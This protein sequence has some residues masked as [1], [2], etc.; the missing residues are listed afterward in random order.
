[1]KTI[2]A[3]LVIALA[4]LGAA[5]G[6]I[7][8]GVPQSGDIAKRGFTKADF[9]RWKELAPNVYAYEGLEFP[10]TAEIVV[11]TV[12]LIVITPDGVVVVDGQG[13]LR[14][15]QEMIDTIKAW[16]P[17][18]IR[19]V[20]VASD[21][22]DHVGGNAAFKAAYPDVVFMSSPVSQRNLAKNANPPTETVADKRVITLG[23]TEI[24]VL[25]IGRGHTGGDLV[26]YL[27]ES[28]V[29]F[30][31]ELYMRHIFPALRSGYPSEWLATIKRAQ[32]MDVSWYV[33]GHGF[34]DDMASMK[35]D[36]EGYRVA[37]EYVIAEGKRLHALGLPCPNTGKPPSCEALKHAKWG[38]YI[39]WAWDE[40]QAR[41]AIAKVYQ[42][43]EG[44]LPQ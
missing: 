10:D 24:Q 12:S 20:V 29:L 37:L 19:Y 40:N 17:Q 36:L 21:H 9:P 18:P 28:K 41:L 33:P 1:M 15:T 8:A 11:T 6:A 43:I 39:D 26:A 25:S 44:R 42:E 35:A 3:L 23:G 22:I 13:D 27:P 14:Q 38:P 4:S 31:G 32:A 7:A 2:A 5:S 34:T 16:T 30:M